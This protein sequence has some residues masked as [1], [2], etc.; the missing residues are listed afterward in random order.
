MAILLLYYSSNTL[1]WKVA[2]QCGV[3]DEFKNA[4]TVCGGECVPGLG[5]EPDAP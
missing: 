5:G 3:T 1:R 2:D 4:A